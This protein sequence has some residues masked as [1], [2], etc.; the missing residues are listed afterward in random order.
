MVELRWLETTEPA[1]V[2]H[3]T[4]LTLPAVT[5]R[6]LQYRTHEFYRNIDTGYISGGW[7]EWSPWIDVPTVRE[8][9]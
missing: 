2:N 4:G 5:K 7:G 8:E 9:C 6:V 3:Q 1:Y